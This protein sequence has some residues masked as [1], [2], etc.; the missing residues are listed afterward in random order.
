M[1]CFAISELDINYNGDLN[2]AK[3]MIDKT[4]LARVD[5]VKFHKRDIDLVYGK[6]FLKE[7]NFLD[8]EKSVAKKLRAHIQI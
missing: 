1:G 4:V 8:I 3:R 6:D 7:K 2:L 5:A